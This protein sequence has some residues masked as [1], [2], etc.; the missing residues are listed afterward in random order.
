MR[1]NGNAYCARDNLANGTR[2]IFMS[3]PCLSVLSV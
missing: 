2:M 3:E 1:D